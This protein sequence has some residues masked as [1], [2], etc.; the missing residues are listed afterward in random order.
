MQESVARKCKCNFLIKTALPW[1]LAVF[2]TLVAINYSSTTYDETVIGTRDFSV[3]SISEAFTA[4]KVEDLK[5]AIQ[6]TVSLRDKQGIER[7]ASIDQNQKC[8]IDLRDVSGKTVRITEKK[9]EMKR[10]IGS[11]VVILRAE[12]DALSKLAC[13]SAQIIS[14]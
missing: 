7:F 5:P 8:S 3:A 4:T 9:V 2:S 11:T 10:I 6:F 12:G 14:S 13:S 1:T